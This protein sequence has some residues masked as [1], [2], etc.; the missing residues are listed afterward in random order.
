[1]KKIACIALSVVIFSCASKDE[2]T[3]GTTTDS[4]KNEAG[5][6]NVN[7]NIPDTTNAINLSTEKKDT[8]QSPDSI[9]K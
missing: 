9:K 2:K 5:V 7:G 6:Q 3:T 4:A 8:L 1:M